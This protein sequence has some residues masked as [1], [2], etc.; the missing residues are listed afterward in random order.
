MGSAAK[1]Q[2]A[3]EISPLSEDAVPSGW[4]QISNPRGSM[5]TADSNEVGLG[6]TRRQ[7]LSAGRG[8]SC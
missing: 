6:L 2:G 1:S 3:E 7:V 8:D 4:V 5:E